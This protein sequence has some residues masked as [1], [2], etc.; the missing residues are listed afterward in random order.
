MPAT[1]YMVVDPR[2]DHS[3]RV[4][5][6]DLSTSLGVPNACNR[7]HR[8]R[9]SQ[10]ASSAIENWYGKTRRPHFGEALDA[11]RRQLP[12]ADSRLAA[13]AQDRGAPGI[14]RGTALELLR[15]SR[16]PDAIAA[17]AT[18]AREADPFVRL[19]A[20][21]GSAL[22][23]P[24][25]RHRLAVPLLSDPVRQVR[26][27]AARLLSEV[28]KEYFTPDQRPT[29]DRAL[30]EYRQAQLRNADWPE[31]HMN[32]ALV[33]L[34][35]G[36]LAE[37]GKEYESALRIDP[38]FTSAYV[39]LADLRR[40]EGRDADAE[41]LLRRALDRAPEAADIH[42]ALGLALVRLKQYEAALPHLRRATE[43]SPDDAR[44]A[45]V[46]GVALEGAGDSDAAIRTLMRAAEVHPGAG[47][48][49]FAIASFEEKRGRISSAAEYARRLL[50]A[51]PGDPGARELLER[52]ESRR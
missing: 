33:H 17:I 32:L 23:D 39:N 51:S 1:T 31:S 35:G 37:A 18:G 29:L 26:M 7:C 38:S 27:E 42:H 28:P 6:P 41:A 19:G 48:I 25:A 21:E 45:Y 44:Y 34:A 3:F 40:M 9:S 5:R 10:W 52:L 46:Y 13:L 2:H 20:L 24:G 12:G 50:E 36:E 30:E 8:D 49:L 22:F 11:G 47:E 16:S 4:P 14:V 15:G 43:L